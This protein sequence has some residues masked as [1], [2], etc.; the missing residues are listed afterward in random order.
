M[1]AV[2]MDNFKDFEDCLQ[3]KCAETINAQYILT[4]N[5]KDFKESTIPAIT[6]ADFLADKG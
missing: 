4:N 1:N 3:N 6:P 5:V 2:D